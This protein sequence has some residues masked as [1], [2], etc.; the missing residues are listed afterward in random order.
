MDVGA[1]HA[2]EIRGEGPS[3]LVLVHGLACDQRIWS[4][5]A[6]RPTVG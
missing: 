3:T 5:L 6:P 4:A 2:M 1:R